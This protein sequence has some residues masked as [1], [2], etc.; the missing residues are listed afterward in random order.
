MW[1][2]RASERTY[3]LESGQHL[4]N[5]QQGQQQSQAQQQQQQQAPQPYDIS[6]S[7]LF[8]NM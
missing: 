6:G 7:V 1:S 5:P 2:E 8:G 3:D 4:N